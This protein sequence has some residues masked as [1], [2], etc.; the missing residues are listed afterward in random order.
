MAANTTSLT[1]RNDSDVIMTIV[2]EP[3]C[4]EYQLPPN[5]E[6]IVELD[7][8]Q[9]GIALYHHI[10][11]GRITVRI[12]DERSNGYS[13]YHNGLEVFE[14][15][16]NS[17][18]TVV[19]IDLNG[20]DTQADF[21]LKMKREL[22]FPEWYGANWDAFWDTITALVEMPKCVVLKNWQTF[23]WACPH[24]LQI[25]HQIMADYQQELPGKSITL[26]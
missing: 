10:E 25:L 18:P 12:I 6:A 21:H 4:F 15:L 20:I 2:R 1:I 8:V 26:G 19:N 7:S 9:K 14:R 5:E 17:Y 24:D 16:M 22:H 11:D 23:A 13:V 3:E